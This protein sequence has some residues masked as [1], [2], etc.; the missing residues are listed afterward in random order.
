MGELVTIAHQMAEEIML[1]LSKDR[2]YK[3]TR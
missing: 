3:R 2:M 1:L